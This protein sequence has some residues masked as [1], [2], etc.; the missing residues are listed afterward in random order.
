MRTQPTVHS[1]RREGYLIRA[2]RT[3]AR[4]TRNVPSAVMTMAISDA[5]MGRRERFGV[6][7]RCLAIR[8]HLLCCSARNPLRALR[9]ALGVCGPLLPDCH[10]PRP[11]RDPHSLPEPE[12]QNY[13]PA[14]E[15]GYSFSSTPLG[16]DPQRRYAEPLARKQLAEKPS[17]RK[18]EEPPKDFTSFGSPAEGNTPTCCNQSFMAVR[19]HLPHCYFNRARRG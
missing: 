2:D 10:A 11:L 5:L 12:A 19:L 16:L 14:L 4:P 8:N 6:S 3:A 13:R 7:L 1:G 15:N 9:F 17:C 18:K